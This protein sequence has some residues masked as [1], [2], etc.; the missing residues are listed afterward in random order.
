MKITLLIIWL[1]VSSLSLFAG[2]DEA[3]YTGKQLGKRYANQLA[4]LD[5]QYWKTTEEI[6]GWCTSG[7][8]EHK[9]VQHY[10]QYKDLFID[11][12]VSGYVANKG[13]KW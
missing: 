6:R 3:W 13:K 2:S 1:G 8:Y 7:L 11:S 5:K 4:R 12:C 9:D 10:M